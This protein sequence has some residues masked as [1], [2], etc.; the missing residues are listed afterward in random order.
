MK[1]QNF[2]LYDAGDSAIDKAKPWQLITLIGCVL[3]KFGGFKRGEIAIKALQ[4]DR[5]A[6]RLPTNVGQW[7]RH[8]LLED[9]M[10]TYDEAIREGRCQICLARIFRLPTLTKGVDGPYD[11]NVIN[12]QETGQFGHSACFVNTIPDDIAQDRLDIIA[13]VCELRKFTEDLPDAMKLRLKDGKRETDPVFAVIKKPGQEPY[14][15]I[16]N[17]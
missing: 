9:R 15:E 11:E 2:V 10:Y 1:T 8:Y 16:R 7:D 4:E 13:T 14:I 3:A 12:N 6:N 5:D 17:A